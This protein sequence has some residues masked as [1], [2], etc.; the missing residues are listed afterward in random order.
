MA[1]RTRR[2]RRQGTEKQRQFT[3][4]ETTPVE[5]TLAEAG[6]SL[7]GEE[8]PPPLKAAQ[9]ASIGNRKEINFAQEYFYVYTELR[10]ILIITLIMFV[11][12]AGLAFVI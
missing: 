6:P 3:S 10:T 7:G 12:M 1:K 11:V 4:P 5:P 9:A 8:F 2:E